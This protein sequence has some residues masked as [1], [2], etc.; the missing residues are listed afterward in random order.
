V[1]EVLC[2]GLLGIAQLLRGRSRDAQPLVERF[3]P[4]LDD[5]RFLEKAS[6]ARVERLDAR[7]LRQQVCGRDLRAGRRRHDPGARGHGNDT[8]K[9]K[10]GVR[11]LVDGGSGTDQAVADRKLDKLVGV[12]RVKTK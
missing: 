8:F 9:A 2:T 1:V 5:V 7:R 12:E 11:D 6:M 4:L 10:D 3:A